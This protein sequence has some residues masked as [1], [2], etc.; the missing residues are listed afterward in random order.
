MKMI[1]FW[2]TTR[3]GVAL[4]RRYTSL[5]P[6]PTRITSGFS[7]TSERPRASVY[8]TLYFRDPP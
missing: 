3:A 1:S 2:L 7:A 4:P 5:L 8:R 6:F